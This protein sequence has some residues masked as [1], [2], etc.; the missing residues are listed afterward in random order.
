[1]RLIDAD[2]FMQRIESYN[3][4]DEMDK[5]LY[6]F[7]LHEIVCMPTVDVLDKIRGEIQKVIN[8]ERDFTSENAKAQVIALNWCLEIIDKYRE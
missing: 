1:M 7:A 6:N 5:A 3:T 4:L 2:L 8:A